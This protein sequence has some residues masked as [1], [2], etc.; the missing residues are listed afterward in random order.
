MRID[1][2]VLIRWSLG[3]LKWNGGLAHNTTINGMLAT[4]SNSVELSN[5]SYVERPIAMWSR[6][7]KLARGDRW[8][9]EKGP[10]L[11]SKKRAVQTPGDEHLFP[12][13][14]SRLVLVDTDGSAEENDMAV[15]VLQ[16]CPSP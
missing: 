13:K 7:K 9:H 10:S 11:K 2:R 3:Q 4:G 5:L 15:F 1:G 16:H 8:S 14:R 6:C 12:T